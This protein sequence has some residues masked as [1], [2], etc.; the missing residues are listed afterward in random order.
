MNYK[1]IYNMDILKQFI[2]YLPQLKQDECYYVSLFAR[3]KYS[4]TVSLKADKCQLKRFTSKKE[5]LVQKIQ[6]LECAIGSYQQDGIIIPQEALAC[7]ISANPRSYE[8]AA[9]ESLKKFAELI[10]KPYGGYNP[11]QEVM[12]EIQKAFSRKIYMDFDFDCDELVYLGDIIN[13]SACKVLKTRGGYHILV[14]LQEIE[15]KYEK[16]WY[17][18]ITNLPGVDVKGDNLIPVCGTLQGN[19]EVP[20]IAPYDELTY[21][22]TYNSLKYFREPKKGEI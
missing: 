11:H 4:T 21:M 3:K 7:Y 1:I 19:F 18:N 2:D 5:Y 13:L 16:T 12:S 8:K 20:M 14:K 6:Q 10:T 15:K 9:K 22:L 17:K